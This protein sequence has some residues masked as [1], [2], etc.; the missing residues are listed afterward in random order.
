MFVYNNYFAKD[1][2]STK[3][4]LAPSCKSVINNEKIYNSKNK[5]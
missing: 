1:R 4:D 3:N 2:K 5:K